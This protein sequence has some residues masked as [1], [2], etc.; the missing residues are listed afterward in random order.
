MIGKSE[1]ESV[2]RNMAAGI[3][4]A[5]TELNHL[6]NEIGD[7]DHGTNMDRGFQMIVKRLPELM[8]HDDLGKIFHEA[9][10]VLLSTIGGSAGPLYSKLFLQAGQVCQGCREIEEKRLSIALQAAAMGASQIGMSTEGDKTMLDALFPACRALQ[11]GL[12]ENK[13][14]PEAL[15]DAVEAAQAGVEYTKTIVA[16]KGRASYLGKRS[17]GHAD[18][19]AVSS[20][21]LLKS[22]QHSLSQNRD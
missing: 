20:C 8:Q 1:I 14:L 22:L 3:H 4:E 12:E 11:K 6:D 5:R 21:L 17:L 2:L 18:P 19:G 9:G 7:G 16:N 10:M 15:A 13:P